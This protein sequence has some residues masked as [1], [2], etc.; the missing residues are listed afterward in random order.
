MRAPLAAGIIAAGLPSIARSQAAS[1]KI[2][3]LASRGSISPHELAAE[4]GYFKGLGIELENV[5][6]AAGGPESLFALASGSVDLGSAATPAVI[7]SIAGGNDFV[8][9]YPS[10]GINSQ[11]KSVFYV[12]E[13]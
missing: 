5:G 8:A 11:V 9:A 12:L 2:R 7:N 13:D 3:Y 1:V 10:N 4:L 6:Y